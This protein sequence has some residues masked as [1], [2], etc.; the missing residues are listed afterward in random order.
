MVAHFISTR[1]IVELCL[2]VERLPGDRVEKWWWEKKKCGLQ[3]RRGTKTHRQRGRWSWR[4]QRDMWGGIYGNYL[5]SVNT[6][7]G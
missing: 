4:D 2:K 7:S 1:T 5:F 6:S 3:D